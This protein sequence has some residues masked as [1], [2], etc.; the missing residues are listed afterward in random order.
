MMRFLDEVEE[1]TDKQ[2]VDDDLNEH[3]LGQRGIL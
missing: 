1:M 3:P 2:R